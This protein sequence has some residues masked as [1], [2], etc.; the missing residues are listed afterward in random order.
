MPLSSDLPMRCIGYGQRTQHKFLAIP[1]PAR[2]AAPPTCSDWRPATDP[3]YR[4][5]LGEEWLFKSCQ[6]QQ[7]TAHQKEEWS[8]FPRLIWQY[9]NH[10]TPPSTVRFEWLRDGFV[11]A[12]KFIPTLTLTGSVW[13]I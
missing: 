12:P 4:I 9:L 2:W 10:P 8:L 1:E 3:E 11:I 7:S 13:G 5:Q 6:R